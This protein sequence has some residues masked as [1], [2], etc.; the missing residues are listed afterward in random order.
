M[1]KILLL[2]STLLCT[3]IQAQN[4]DLNNGTDYIRVQKNGLSTFSRA[5]GLNDSNQLYIGSVEE[6]IGNIY[7]FN[8]GTDYLMTLTPNGNVGIG[9]T[10]P[11]SKIHIKE[12][13]GGAAMS[14][15]RGG[16]IWNLSIQ[17]TGDNLFLKNTS[18]PDNPFFTFTKDGKF[19]INTTNPESFL[20]INQSIRHNGLTISE[21][22][23]SLKIKLHLAKLDDGREYGFFDL[24]GNTKIRGNGELSTFDGSIAIGTTS[25][26]SHK[27]AVEGS[28]GAREIK[29]QATGWSDFVFENDYNLPTLKEVE[30]HIKQK[31][32][33]K[34][35]PSAAQV[36][37]N[38]ILLGEMDAKLLQK[39][40]ELTLYTIQQ[41][42]EIEKLKKENKSL[43]EISAKLTEI[44]SRLEKL[45]SK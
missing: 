33:L 30:Q 44:Q 24:G 38:G 41:Q 22:D 28:I 35:I 27:L 39:I 43:K 11:Q 34:D 5:F 18:D 20:H 6:S 2:T 12:P 1:K 17:H 42:K 8:K 4:I 10:T 40:E 31:G 14:I 23:N 32:H 36:E 3:I 16:K 21:D 29:V 7:L 13:L 37:E 26:G 45:E 25:T 9:T 19:G 15:E